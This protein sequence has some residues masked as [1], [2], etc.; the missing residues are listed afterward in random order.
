MKN[1]L[2]FTFIIL[3]CLIVN[4]YT[5]ETDYT[6][7]INFNTCINN[8]GTTCFIGEIFHLVSVVLQLV[9]L[10]VISIYFVLA[11]TRERSS[12]NSIFNYYQRSVLLV[13]LISALSYIAYVSLVMYNV[14][15][16]SECI[17]SEIYKISLGFAINVLL[18]F[19]AFMNY[20]YLRM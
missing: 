3:L 11:F 12:V 6:S 13:S 10:V 20:N 5:L 18:L 15:G 14:S 2:I 4:F 17:N 9:L 8:V 1:I 16:S 7:T 19:L